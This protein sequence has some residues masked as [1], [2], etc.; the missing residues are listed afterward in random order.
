MHS[1]SRWTHDRN[2]RVRAIIDSKK[3]ILLHLRLRGQNHLAKVSVPTLGTRIAAAEMR[4][5]MLASAISTRAL[6]QAT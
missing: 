3:L 2:K 4:L 5:S 6:T 1:A